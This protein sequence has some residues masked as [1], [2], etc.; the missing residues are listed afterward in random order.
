MKTKKFLSMAA[1]ALVGAMTVSCSSDDNI[2]EQPQQPENKSNVVTLTTTVGIGGGAET[3]ALAADGT[4]TFAAGETMAIIYKNTSGENAVAVSDALQDNGDIINEGKSATFTF[5]LDSPDKN[6]NVTYIY[7]AAM[8]DNDGNVK[9]DALASQD[10]TLA[11]LA[12]NLDYCTN[13]GAWTNGT[14]LPSLTLDNQFAIL[15]LTLKNGAGSR[16]ITSSI[17]GLTVSDGTNSY[18]VSRSA[19]DG[20]IYVAIRPTTAALELTATDGSKN[21]TKTATSREYAAGNG[22][23]LPLKM[24]TV[25]SWNQSELKDIPS[26]YDNGSRTLKGVTL[27]KSDGI[28]YTYDE[29]KYFGG[30]FQ[31]S[32]ILGNL[33][34]IEITTTYGSPVGDGWSG[35]VWTGNASTVNIAE[36]GFNATNIV[37]T[38]AEDD[39]AVTGISLN[40]T[41]TSIEAGKTET[42]TATILPA[43][44]TDKSVTWTS[45]NTSVATVDAS[46]VVTAVAT[47]EATITAEASNGS[48][49]TCT[50]TV[51]AALNSL[52]IKTYYGTDGPTIY[53]VSGE[54]W[55]QA[56]NR[57]S[58]NQSAAGRWYIDNFYEYIMY[59]VGGDYPFVIGTLCNPFFE[60]ISP[61]TVI[62]PSE[63]EWYEWQ[64]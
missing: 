12:S 15:A 51:T 1:L 35:N 20:P 55:S 46:G 64:D 54:T 41:S 25:I 58:E 5:T 45:S 28:F 39:V 37:F 59:E 32:S 60:P 27:T 8:V 43:E 31:F 9:D 16:E 44:A 23:S 10:G 50:V 36:S 4:K 11:S 48:T 52:V 61:N 29:G 33:T 17:T 40:K 57:H 53:Y 30:V 24:L 49:A 26:M 63:P 14:D 21:Y 42:L 6:E 62:N 34:K 7:P 2:I 47:G 18:T 56:I 38:I 3:R 13:S 22:Y 19:A